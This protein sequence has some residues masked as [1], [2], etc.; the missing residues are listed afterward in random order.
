VSA[1]SSPYIL[2]SN[3]VLAASGTGTNAGV[4][5]AT[6]NGAPGGT[7]SLGSQ[8]ITLAY[9]G[10]D[11]S[12]YI[13][14]GTLTL[15]GNAFAVNSASPLAHGAYTIVQQASGTLSSSGAITVSGTAI[16]TGSNAYLNVTGPAVK[17]EINNPPVASVFPVGTLVN[18]PV[19]FTVAQL[20]QNASDADGDTLILSALDSTSAQGGTIVNASGTITYTPSNNFTGTDAF[21]Y[22]V[23][24]PFGATATSLV[25][26]VVR[27]GNDSSLL[28]NLVTLGK[29]TVQFTAFGI[30]NSIY[31]VQATTNLADPSSW[32][33]IGTVTAD[34][35]G[36]ILYNALISTNYSARFYRLAQ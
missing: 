19:S 36:L 6:I 20:L 28:S 13:S 22:T 9:D 14:Q 30:T 27:S 15:H 29:G 8:P 32:Q 12:L 21:S 24:D 23:S 1:I 26:V 34:T 35:N 33:T 2:S 4:T 3:T 5:A 17:L 10:S 25:N 31:N 18:T 16:P 7:V 11:P